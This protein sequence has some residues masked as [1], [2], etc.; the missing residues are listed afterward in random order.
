[1]NKKIENFNIYENNIIS[2]EAAKVVGYNIERFCH[3]SSESILSSIIF[4]NTIRNC[5]VVEDR[6]ISS[7]ERFRV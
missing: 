4:R 1:M 6:F 5:I 3:P 2:V 7:K